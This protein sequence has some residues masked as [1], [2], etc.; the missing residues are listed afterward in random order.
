[1][2]SSLYKKTDKN[3]SFGKPFYINFVNCI[4]VESLKLLTPKIEFGVYF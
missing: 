2:Y 3:L 1:M 4:I